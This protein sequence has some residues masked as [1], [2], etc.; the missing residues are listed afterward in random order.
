MLRGWGGLR[1]SC[2]PRVFSEAED[3]TLGLQ[4]VISGLGF[5]LPWGH[6]CKSKAHSLSLQ[7]PLLVA[8]E[9]M[10]GFQA[11][12]VIRVHESHWRCAKWQLAAGKVMEQSPRGQTGERT[13]NL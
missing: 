1:W 4:T 5:S 13:G 7:R 12:S 9:S 6:Q 10:A 3:V 11:L 2:Y 8:A